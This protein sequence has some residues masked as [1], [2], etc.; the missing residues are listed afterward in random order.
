V[1]REQFLS[2]AAVRDEGNYTRIT[3]RKLIAFWGARRRGSYIVDQIDRDLARHNLVAQPS[4][5]EVWLDERITLIPV[6][7][8]APESSSSEPS[9][10]GT[11]ST[12]S[13]LTAT[14]PQAAT[15]QV[16]MLQSARSAVVAV[17][18]DDDLIRAQSL[19]MR[20]DYSQLAVLSGPRDLRGAVSWESVAQAQIR[21]PDASLRDATVHS[22]TVRK[23]DDLLA[24]VP[25]IVDEG[26]VFV[27][28]N[29]RTITG[30]V[31][32]ADLSNQF[33]GL[34]GPFLM[35]GEIERR[36]R[37][38]A[39]AVFQEDDFRAVVDPRDT[40]RTVRNAGDL[41]LGEHIKLLEN[42]DR[43]NRLSWKLDRKIFIEILDGIRKARNEIMHF[44][45]DP[46]DPDDLQRMQS[47]LKWIRKLH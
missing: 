8:E 37:Q 10:E 13:E 34:A 19:M 31:T 38:I 7:H 16:G 45:P 2:S 44:S 3:V 47:F 36:L 17:R 11:I 23:T 9:V 41:T 24:L 21:D 6:A 28:N 26:F 30:I 20:H 25:T 35:L 14:H 39:D 15:L 4:I 43:W 18:P 22:R 1:D 32:T 5:I 27:Q 42:P 40:G 29:D 33:V 12:N 46:L